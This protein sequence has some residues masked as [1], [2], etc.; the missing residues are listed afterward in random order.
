M[1]GKLPNEH[2]QFNLTFRDKSIA[3]EKLIVRNV[4]R[5]VG[6]ISTVIEPRY[7]EY[8][9]DKLH[10]LAKEVHSADQDFETNYIYMHVVFEF[11]ATMCEEMNMTV[12]K[13]IENIKELNK[14]K[15]KDLDKARAYLKK[16][17]A[18]FTNKIIE[19]T[20][21]VKLGRRAPV[22]DLY[23]QPPTSH[24]WQLLRSITTNHTFGD[25]ETV[26]NNYINFACKI[27]F[28]MAAISKGAGLIPM[29]EPE[30]NA[31]LDRAFVDPLPQFPIKFANTPDA[32]EE[33]LDSVSATLI[34]RY[35][36]YARNPGLGMDDGAFF[37]ANPDLRIIRLLFNF[38]EKSWIR[39]IRKAWQY[40]SVKTDLKHYI[41]IS[42]FD[43]FFEPARPDMPRML[44][45]NMAKVILNK[46][47]L[48]QDDLCKKQTEGIVRVRLVY[49]GK[50]KDM[51]LKLVTSPKNNGKEKVKPWIEFKE[52]EDDEE[53]PE[54]P[55]LDDRLKISAAHMLE[56]VMEIEKPIEDHF[57]RRLD[58]H[59]GDV[60]PEEYSRT[61][62]KRINPSDITNIETPSHKDD[63]D[64]LP[65]PDC[66]PK[67]NMFA[68]MM[69]VAKKSNLIKFGVDYDPKSMGTWLNNEETKDFE[70]VIV[71][72]HGGGFVAQSSSSHQLYLNKWANEFKIPIFS[73]DY[74]LAPAV[75]FPEPVNDV[76]TSYLWLLNYLEFILQVKPKQ[77]I[78]IGDSAGGNLLTCLTTWCIMNRVRAPDSLLMFYPAMSLE[79]DKF[80]PSVLFAINDLML[81][82]SALKMCGLYYVGPGQDPNKNPFLSPCVLDEEILC[83]FPPMHLYVSERDPLRD[84]CMRFALRAHKAGAFVRI[85][86]LRSMSHG[87]LNASHKK[88]L[89]EGTL[90]MELTSATITKIIKDFVN[91]DE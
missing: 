6:Q 46:F 28:M 79:A 3:L 84:D 48:I 40:P 58:M 81:N 39:V 62:F 53:V 71:H 60:P 64:Y 41:N 63:P 15:G 75:Q 57:K 45:A 11:A 17:L 37:V 77:I 26:I 22:D 32:T 87:L 33:D 70:K 36:K 34:A 20:Q 67:K 13:N 73:I 90:F 69:K 43:E 74:R 83:V 10:S 9:A 56:K 8:V 47:H 85:N 1:E 78:G 18:I 66:D 49:H 5:L 52:D 59:D 35:I 24:D 4:D 7:T 21:L 65:T 51:H 76:I 12:S 44:R 61:L 54:E 25:S 27:F 29:T 19:M 23:C 31:F 50:L 42:M 88:G 55:T 30:V 68:A 38:P 82:Y 2:S 72:I 16:R 80:S 14:K 91:K 86:Y 89:P